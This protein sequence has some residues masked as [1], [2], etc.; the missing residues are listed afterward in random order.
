MD[1]DGSVTWHHLG[2]SPVW[3]WSGRTLWHWQNK[4][5]IS[6]VHVDIF[7]VKLM[8]NL[9]EW[10]PGL[11]D[12]NRNFA[13]NFSMAHISL[14]SWGRIRWSLIPG[15]TAEDRS[16]EE[17]TVIQIFMGS[18]GTDK[19]ARSSILLKMCK[20]KALIGKKLIVW[21]YCQ[22]VH[23]VHKLEKDWK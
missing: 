16:I 23:C 12:I 15:V 14:L 5:V 7:L 3:T 9:S 6:A 20:C 2:S 21:S 19:T 18:S 10:K 4:N 8:P 22:A 11:L 17:W 13:M 1:L